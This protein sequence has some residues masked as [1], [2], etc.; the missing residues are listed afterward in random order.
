MW[1]PSATPTVDSCS[2][3]SGIKLTLLE[4]VSS[5]S[6]GPPKFHFGRS[7][8]GQRPCILGL[9]PLSSADQ[10]SQF[11]LYAYTVG[12]SLSYLDNISATAETFAFLCA[13]PSTTRGH[14]LY[15]PPQNRSS[16]QDSVQSVQDINK[17]PS[18]L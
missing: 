4:S 8:F 12:L 9:L 2:P 7:M 18:T 13:A 10:S 16:T 15:F 5:R 1:E 11:S 3:R 14:A 17:F 6:S